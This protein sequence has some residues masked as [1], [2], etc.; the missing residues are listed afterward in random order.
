MSRA[1]NGAL[2]TSAFV[3]VDVLANSAELVMAL[4]APLLPAIAYLLGD[5]GDE[6]G[7]N[8]Q[9]VTYLFVIFGTAYVLKQI[10]TAGELI[11]DHVT[12]TDN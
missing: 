6:L 3:L 9:I 8:Q 2:A 1:E 5:L 4:S 12:E 11:K 7:V 10:L